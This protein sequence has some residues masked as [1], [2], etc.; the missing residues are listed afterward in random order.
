MMS[1]PFMRE[2]ASGLVEP[3]TDDAR[4]MRCGAQALLYVLDVNQLQ[5]FTCLDCHGYVVIKIIRGEL[6][7][8]APPLPPLS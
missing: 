7:D 6:D 1:A 3:G 2:P 8:E 5:W 4:C